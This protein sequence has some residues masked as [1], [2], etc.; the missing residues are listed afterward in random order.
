[1]CDGERS[2]DLNSQSLKDLRA[3][4]LVFLAVLDARTIIADLQHHTATGQRE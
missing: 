2:A 3:E 4:S 1:M